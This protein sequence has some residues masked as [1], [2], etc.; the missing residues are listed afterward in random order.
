[1]LLTLLLPNALAA[2][3]DLSGDALLT[4]AGFDAV[5]LRG[6]VEVRGSYT[7]ADS[8][9]WALTERI[10]PQLRVDLHERITL[11]TTFEARL[12]Q[13][14]YATGEL[15]ELMRPTIE[16]SLGGLS[17]GGPSLEEVVE[18]CA[19]DVD[20]NRTYDEI[21]D[22]ASIERLFLDVK[23]PAADI[24]VGRQPVNWGSA[25]FFNPTD[26]FSQVLLTEPWQERA[27]V[28]AARVNV[29]IGDEAQITGLVAALDDYQTFRGG[30]RGSVHVGATDIA[31]IGSSDGESWFAGLDAKGDFE[32]GWWVEGG[33]QGD[34]TGTDE[35]AMKVAAGVDYSFNVMEHLYV[36]TQVYHDGS[37]QI[38]ALY[39][40]SSRQDPTLASLSTCAAYPEIED[41]LPEVP[42]EYRLTLGQWYGLLV[43]QLGATEDLTIT[44]TTALNL[45]DQTGLL[46]PTAA[47]N[48]GSRVTLNGGVQYL[49]GG[50]GEFQPPD[51]QLMAG[52][53]DISS[54]Y[55]TW[56][57][58]AWA[59]V[60]L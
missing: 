30:L 49:F 22:V 50:E 5:S 58:M 52:E 27:G 23:L 39:D 19:W 3:V 29:P 34:L 48:I 37:G 2:P 53:V 43:A 9:H 31:V 7:D 15:L 13:G 11:K 16:G 59:R 8:T 45:A 18:E 25:L 60:S 55:P 20:V 14:R 1:M 38:P 46:F 54:L 42:D 41:Y 36:A 56:T 44:A 28:D 26:I 32:V 4:G 57:A 51:Y 35:G 6:Y 47:Y 24:R 33:F 12:D 17:G 21:G 40:W 10:R